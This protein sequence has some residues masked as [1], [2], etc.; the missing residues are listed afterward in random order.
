L[1]KSIQE[2]QRALDQFR[3][4]GD[5]RSEALTLFSIGLANW[6]LRGFSASLDHLMQARHIWQDLEHPFAETGASPI[7]TY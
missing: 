4:I 5:R 6:F 3:L 7:L 2:F 1:Q